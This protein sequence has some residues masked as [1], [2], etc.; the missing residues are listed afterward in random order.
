MQK[1]LDWSETKA[2]L[3]SVN[4]IYKEVSNN[5]LSLGNNGNFGTCHCLNWTTLRISVT[6]KVPIV[7]NNHNIKGIMQDTCDMLTDQGVLKHS[8]SVSVS[9]I[10]D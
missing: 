6:R 4:R 5:N 8:N 1:P 3:D 9:F 2:F 7:N 10:P